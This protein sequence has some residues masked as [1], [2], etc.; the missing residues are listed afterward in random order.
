MACA[1]TLA[2]HPDKFHVTLF[3]AAEHAGGQ[4]TSIDLDPKEHG[5]SFMNDGV[6]GLSLFE[7]KY[8]SGIE[9]GLRQ[10]VRPFL[11]TLITVFISLA[12]KRA[13]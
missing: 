8:I 3:E 7:Q 4:A 2:Q 5:A 1:S 10:A 13:M 9:F 11:S 12:S 6:Q